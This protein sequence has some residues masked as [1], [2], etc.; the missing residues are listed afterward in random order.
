MSRHIEIVIQRGTFNI[1]F[2]AVMIIKFISSENRKPPKAAVGAVKLFGLSLRTVQEGSESPVF[3]ETQ[4]PAQ[5]PV[6]D[7]NSVI[8]HEH[9]S[10]IHDFAAATSLDLF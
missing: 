9:V 8:L 1:I 5:H 7:H 6:I 4:Q 10:H 3:G 2:Y